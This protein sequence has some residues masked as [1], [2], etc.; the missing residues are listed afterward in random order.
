MRNRAKFQV[1]PCQRRDKKRRR[2]DKTRSSDDEPRKA[3]A[4]FAQIDGQFRRT[5]AGKKAG[6]ARQIEKSLARHPPA[7][8]DEFLFHHGNVGGGPAVGDETE[9][10]KLFRDFG[11]CSLLSFIGRA[12]YPHP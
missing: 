7:A 5:W 8:A 2:Q 6:G 1:S 4:N 11:E 12:F 9:A 3:G 10:Q